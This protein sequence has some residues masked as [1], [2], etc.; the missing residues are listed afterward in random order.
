MSWSLRITLLLVGV[1]LCAGFGILTWRLSQGVRSQK[2]G[3]TIIHRPALSRTPPASPVGMKRGANARLSR[4]NLAP[5]ATVTVSSVEERNQANEGVVDDVPDERQWVSAG[6]TAGAWIELEWN[7]P[8]LVSEIELHD[9][10]SLVENILRGTLLFDDGSA[11]PVPPLP[12][13][14][15]AWRSTFPPRM[16]RRLRFRIDKVAGRSTGLAE[17]MVFGP[18]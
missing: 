11:I 9:R 15:S 13:D 14:G 10:S 16:T 2:I 17:I 12:P 1:G 6:E 18:L 3:G 7:E 5:L 4:L 8:M